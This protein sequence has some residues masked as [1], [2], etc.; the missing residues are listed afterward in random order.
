MYRLVEQLVSKSVHTKKLKNINDMNKIF[1]K[2]F[3]VLTLAFALSMT[4]C[5]TDSEYDN[6]NIGINP[7]NNKNYVEVHI[8]SNDNTNIISR[9]FPLIGRD[10]TVTKF[11]AFNLTSGPATSDVTISYVYLGT[12]TTKT[13]YSYVVDSLVNIKGL[14]IGDATKIT[15]LNQGKVVIP[16]GQSTGYIAVKLNAN[17]LIGYTF[18][19]GVRI[20]AVSDKK[21]TIS[22]LTDGI[23]K[24]GPAN[25][26]DG[27]YTVDG[28]FVDAAHP[29]FTG[30]YPMD[31]NLETQSLTTN[32]MRDLK[33]NG[34]TIGHGFINAGSG[35]YYGSFSPVF[36]FDPV[37][38]KVISVTNYYGQ[39]A[40]NGR[41]AELDP[42]GINTY[43]PDTKTIKVSYWMNQPSVITPHRTHFVEVF[44]YLGPR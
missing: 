28:T 30:S 33:V 11:I 15:D 36:E 23:A 24:F 16:K 19:F 35:S 39:P 22:N 2:I 4:A 9:A 31:V 25:T 7:T 40:S 17:N 12:D 10:T 18:L 44:T 29:E 5:L 14:V 38:N 6:N 34:G 3:P 1:Y 13:N 32:V 37:T 41:S 27:E 42:S 26:Y 8:T 21:Y 20:T 43:D